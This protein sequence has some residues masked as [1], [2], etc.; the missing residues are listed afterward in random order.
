M[1][2]EQ[3]FNNGKIYK[4]VS[5]NTDE[6]YI[7]S[8]IKTLEKRKYGHL[9]AFKQWKD[10][11]P[12]TSLSS[13]RIIEA[14][15][16]EI[17]LLEL[18]PCD[19]KNEL[20]YRERYW[21]EKLK[22]VNIY[23]PIVGQVETKEIEK[24]YKEKNK[25]KIFRRSKEYNEKN[26]EELSEKRKEYNEKNKDR[27]KEWREK[28]KEEQSKKRKEYYEKNKDKL[29]E[30]SKVYNEQNKEKIVEYKKDYYEKNKEKLVERL[31]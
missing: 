24:K 14:G 19:T 25:E 31:I 1:A 26:K 11:K 21:M 23:R 9:S 3:D 29:L 7:G 17:V 15:D 18:Y 12:N 6:I 22:C 2:K 27:Q 5:S 16:V 20:F 10:G 8:T 13:F 28:N 4:L 30:K